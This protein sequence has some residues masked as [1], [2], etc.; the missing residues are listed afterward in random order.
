[1]NHTLDFLNKDKDAAI[2]SLIKQYTGPA[3]GLVGREK[4][5]FIQKIPAIVSKHDF[6]ST[7]IG[8]L[9][10]RLPS[11]KE[12]H[13]ITFEKIETALEKFNK[14]SFP[15]LDSAKQEIIELY[16]SLG[17]PMPEELAAR[18]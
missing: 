11:L 17:G 4:K 7:H 10:A 8:A 5:E 13:P 14:E 18:M 16:E 6:A 2:E 3:I 1:M 12:T 9:Q 15:K